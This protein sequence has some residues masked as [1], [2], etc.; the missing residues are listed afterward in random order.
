MARAVA[1]DDRR[2]FAEPERTAE[3]R[4]RPGVARGVRQGRDESAH[5]VGRARFGAGVPR[6]REGP[7][8]FAR[9]GRHD[10]RRE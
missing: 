10:V 6:P 8:S 9:I 5:H 3:R 1:A 2:A 7:D 4:A